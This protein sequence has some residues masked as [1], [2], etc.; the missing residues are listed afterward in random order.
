MKTTAEIMHDVATLADA[1]ENLKRADLDLQIAREQFVDLGLDVI[2]EYQRAW[3]VYVECA[4]VADTA[5]YLK[6][7]IDREALT[8]GQPSA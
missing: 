5:R 3:R 4:M 1:E 7:N 8:N 2:Q 6:R